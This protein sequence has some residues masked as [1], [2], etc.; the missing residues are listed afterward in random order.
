MSV[1]RERDEEGMDVVVDDEGDECGVVKWVVDCSRMLEE[2]RCSHRFIREGK[3]DAGGRT[4]GRIPIVF[5]DI[6]N[7]R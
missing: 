6:M 4:R 5:V 1:T 3:S 2:T 7:V